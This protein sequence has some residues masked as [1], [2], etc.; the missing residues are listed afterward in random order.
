MRY[1]V[2]LLPA[3]IMVLALG[4]LPALALG[5]APLAAQQ[6]PASA[7]IDLGFVNTSGNTEVTTLNGGEKLSYT[8]KS[9]GVS[10]S[11]SV[12]YGKT[13]GVVSASQWKA[14]LRFDRAISKRFNVFILGNFERNTFAGFNWY[15]EESAG[16]GATLV[17]SGHSTL[18]AELGASLIQQRSVADSTASFVAGRLAANYRYAITKAAYAQQTVEVLPNLQDSKDLRVNSETALVAPISK[19]IAIKLSYAIRFDNKPEPGFKKSDRTF[20][21]GMQIA[22]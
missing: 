13:A 16:L 15:F 8:W 3:P 12:V 14:G 21:S 7:T 17:K 5:A 20:T 11:F 6:K 2:R 4:I 1:H 18:K 22:F 9:W 19:H 10:Q